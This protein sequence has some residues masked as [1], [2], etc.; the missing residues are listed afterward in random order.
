MWDLTNFQRDLLYIIRSC[1]DP[2]GL[3]IKAELDAYY[4]ED[5]N[6]ARLY[7]N[8]ETLIDLGL[9]AK[10]QSD[11]RTNVYSLTDRGIEAIR[12][13]RQWERSV[14]DTSPLTTSS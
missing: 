8:L 12:A 11:G 6:H 3:E 13:R 14:L 10:A 2:C 4:S 5:I 9:V 7:P 1:E